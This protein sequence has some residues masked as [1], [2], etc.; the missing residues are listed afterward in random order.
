MRG[1]QFI[2]GDFKWDKKWKF[3]NKKSTKRYYKLPIIEAYI[4]PIK[5]DPSIFRSNSKFLLDSGATISI[6]N[7]SYNDFLETI[8]SIDEVEIQYGSGSVKHLKVYELNLSLNRITRKMT[9]A[10]D[11]NL[12]HSSLLGYHDF[13]E[14]FSIIVFNNKE[15]LI[16]I[17]AYEN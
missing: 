2:K 4:S 17:R 7:N 14:Q 5:K 10:H 12:E 11:P 3:N 15:Q 1:S 9:F 6:L 13:F 16:K 8:S